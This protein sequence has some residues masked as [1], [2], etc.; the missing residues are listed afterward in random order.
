[1]RKTLTAGTR[2]YATKKNVQKKST[3]KPASHTSF[4][5]IMQNLLPLVGLMRK[6]SLDGGTT[7]PNPKLIL[8]GSGLELC[9][10]GL[11]TPSVQAAP[12]PD[13]QAEMERSM[14][15]LSARVGAMEDRQSYH[16]TTLDSLVAAVKLNEEMLEALVDSLT[17]ADDLSFGQSDLPLGPKTLAS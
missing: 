6:M 5:Q 12:S 17:A 10:S 7:A 8:T 11:E 15:L 3:R 1:M 13:R 9:F 16:G 14:K 4:K 2:R